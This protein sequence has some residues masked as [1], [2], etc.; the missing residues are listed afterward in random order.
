MSKYSSNTDKELV[1]HLRKHNDKNAFEELYNRY[2][3]KL[4]IQALLKLNSEYEAEEVV[5]DVFL[6]LWRRRKTIEIKYTFH[7][8]IASC[9]KYE[10]LNKLAQR[11]KEIKLKS[12]TITHLSEESNT[13]EESINYAALVAQIE[14]TVKALPEKCQLVYRMSREEGLSQKQIAEQLKISQKTIETHINK[15]LKAIRSSI[16]SA[17]FSILF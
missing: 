13:T 14:E 7:T 6:N 8:Y 4:L 12:Q 3:E 15:A 16:K 2:W 11:K 10:I 1:Q 17:L 9:V 5:Q